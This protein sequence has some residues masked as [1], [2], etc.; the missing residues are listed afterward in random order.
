MVKAMWEKQTF[1]PQAP[2]RVWRAVV[3]MVVCVVM[4]LLSG[5]IESKALRYFCSIYAVLSGIGGVNMIAAETRGL[6][7]LMCTSAMLRG[8]DDKIGTAFTPV[9]L[10]LDAGG[11]L[12]ETACWHRD[13]AHGV[14]AP[15]KDFECFVDRVQ[16]LRTTW[17]GKGSEDPTTVDQ[18]PFQALACIP[19]ERSQHRLITLLSPE[20]VLTCVET[21]QDA[22][23]IKSKMA[24]P[25]ETVFCSLFSVL[26]AGHTLVYQEVEVEDGVTA[27]NAGSTA[28]EQGLTLYLV[29]GRHG[30]PCKTATQDLLESAVALLMDGCH[31]L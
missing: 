17:R 23:E 2:E 27:A 7:I 6:T 19:L 3:L 5:I 16:W 4:A 30:G 18:P 1:L 12:W 28:N 26:N 31:S 15:Q 9:R 25:E 24:S 22:Q 14:L 29:G 20:T 13:K 11:D 8:W 21:G 10:A